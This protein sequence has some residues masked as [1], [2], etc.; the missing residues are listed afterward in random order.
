[1]DT[2]ERVGLRIRAIRKQRK[3]TQ[4]QLAE[5][6][7]RSVEAISN[8]ERGVSHPS[9]ETLEGL[10]ATLGVPVKEFFEFEGGGEISPKRAKLLEDLKTAAAELS[11]KQLTIAV[12]QVK[13]LAQ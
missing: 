12:A 9:F 3:L 2:K 10:S 11:D 8:L 4:D 5:K 13:A 1:M 6:L 7:G